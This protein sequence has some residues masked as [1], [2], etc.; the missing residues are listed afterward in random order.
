MFYENFFWGFVGFLLGFG[1]AV[2]LV[3][4]IVT[5]AVETGRIAL[6]ERNGDWFTGKKEKVTYDEK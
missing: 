3:F 4:Y 1:S 6:R 5:Y 2:A